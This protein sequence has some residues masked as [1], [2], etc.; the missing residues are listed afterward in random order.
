MIALLWAL[1]LLGL[2]GAGVV[3]AHDWLWVRWHRRRSTALLRRLTARHIAELVPAQRE[4]GSTLV[5][6]IPERRDGER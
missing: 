3:V 1:P 4:P 5:R 6:I 2:L